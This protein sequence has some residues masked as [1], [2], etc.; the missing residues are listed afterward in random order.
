MEAHAH[1]RLCLVCCWVEKQQ[2]GRLG[3]QGGPRQ[4]SNELGRKGVFR[5]FPRETGRWQGMTAWLSLSCL[6]EVVE[7]AN[8]CLS[9]PTGCTHNLPALS[10][11][12]WGLCLQERHPL[13]RSASFL[14]WPRRERRPDYQ[15]QLWAHG[16][17]NGLRELGSESCWKFHSSLL[18]LKAEAHIS[19]KWT[20][21]EEACGPQDQFSHLFSEDYSTHH[22]R[23]WE[24]IRDNFSKNKHP[25]WHILSP[26]WRLNST[27]LRAAATLND[28]TAINWSCLYFKVWYF[29]HCGF[30]S[31][32]QILK[33]FIT[34]LCILITEFVCESLKFCVWGSW[35]ACFLIIRSLNSLCLR[36]LFWKMGI[37]IAPTKWPC[38]E[39]E[40]C[41][42]IFFLFIFSSSLKWISTQWM[43]GFPGVVLVIRNSL[44]MQVI[45]R[46]AGSIPGWGRSPGEGN[47]NL[48]QYTCWANPMESGA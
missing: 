19:Q 20:D 6:G 9:E 5:T 22:T 12:R 28:W 46:G 8:D 24:R 3:R 42:N 26:K 34:I 48:L 16:K 13:L 47:A 33:Y 35:L 11:P 21:S 17:S 18:S 41:Q 32:V 39:S 37:I 43:L 30:F 40:I 38:A 4:T 44:A 2:W 10:T 36:L 1:A 27:D 23:L 29:V 45:Q 31:L 14:S 15:G 25:A 7:G